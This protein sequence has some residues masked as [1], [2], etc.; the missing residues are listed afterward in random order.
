MNHDVDIT[1]KLIEEERKY[2]ESVTVIGEYMVEDTNAQDWNDIWYVS[3]TY[4]F[5]M[6]PRRKMFNDVKYKFKMMGKEENERK[7]IFSYG[8]GD[9]TIKMK[10][11]DLNIGHIQYTPEVSLNVL[12]L[13]LLETQGFSVKIKDGVCKIYYMYDEEL[14]MYLQSKGETSE[15]V[16]P[17]EVVNEHNEYLQKYFESIDPGEECSLVK[18]LEDL[19]WNK[20]DTQDYV[21]EEYL[22][23]NGTLY[24]LKVNSFSRFLSFMNLIKKDDLLYKNWEIFNKRF[25]DMIKWF[26]LVHL[27]YASL[28][29]IPPVVKDVQMNLLCLHKAVEC[30]GGYFSVTMGDKWG[31]IAQLQ[32]LDIK[33]GEI[34]RGF[35][36]TYIDLVV[37]YH[38]TSSMPWVEKS[39]EVGEASKKCLAMDLQGQQ[40]TRVKDGAID[41]NHFGVKLEEEENG[42]S[43]SGSNDFE[44]VI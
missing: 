18:G 11:G 7:F 26:Y 1:E 17:K 44:V 4:K 28:E 6:C 24:A 32:G 9:V 3:K 12:S 38:E 35:Y 8:V 37:V 30:L 20:Y 25:L 2:P 29:S 41:Q 5:H 40:D 23:F 21:E 31:T 19:D 36:K 16:G 43:S 13:E 33:D 27:N 39:Y 22:S 15:P 14:G 42:S 34:V 10:H